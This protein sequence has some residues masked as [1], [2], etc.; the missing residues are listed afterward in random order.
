MVHL[1]LKGTPNSLNIRMM[2]RDNYILY[3]HFLTREMHDKRMLMM[4]VLQHLHFLS[5][6]ANDMRNLFCG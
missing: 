6:A 3:S 2:S 1:L 4:L 5:F